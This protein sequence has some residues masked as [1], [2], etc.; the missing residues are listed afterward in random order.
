MPRTGGR[1]VQY[2]AKTRW[3]TSYWLKGYFAP[4]GYG[5]RHGNRDAMETGEV[6]FAPR[7]NTWK[8]VGPITVDT[9]KGS[10]GSRTAEWPIVA[11]KSGNADGAK[12]PC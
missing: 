5:R 8:E 4:A 9:G 12:G 6:L 7:R 10:N 2:V 1:A 11:M 3:N